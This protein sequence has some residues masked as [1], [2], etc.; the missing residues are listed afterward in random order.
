MSQLVQKKGFIETTIQSHQ[1][2]GIYETLEKGENARQRLQRVTSTDN[3]YLKIGY[4][5]AFIILMFFLMPLFIT[6]F[7]TKGMHW[8][9]QTLIWFTVAVTGIIIFLKNKVL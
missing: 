1:N 5:I 4:L 6:G 8:V 9:E 2:Y 7:L 3:I